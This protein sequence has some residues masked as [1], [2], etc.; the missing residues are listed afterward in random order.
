MPQDALRKV[1]AGQSLTHEEAKAAVTAI[2]L[3]VPARNSRRV[4]S[5]RPLLP[6]R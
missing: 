6:E 2:M 4:I 3:A 1:A 5:M